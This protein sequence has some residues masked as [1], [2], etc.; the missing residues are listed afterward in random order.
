MFCF[1]FCLFLWHCSCRATYSKTGLQW[2][3]MMM[4]TMCFQNAAVGHWVEWQTLCVDTD[5]IG[6]VEV[7]LAALVI[8]FDLESACCI[9]WAPCSNSPSQSLHGAH[10]KPLTQSLCG[11]FLLPISHL[12]VSPPFSPLLLITVYSTL[13]LLLLI[14]CAN[15]FLQSVVVH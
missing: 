3:V 6:C 15:L 9:S 10:F 1:L 8:R 13:P 2:S 7:T 12:P 11:T 4:K 5:T 14:H